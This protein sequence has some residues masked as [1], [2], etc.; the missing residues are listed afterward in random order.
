M[1]PDILNILVDEYTKKNL[2]TFLIRLPGAAETL[3]REEKTDKQNSNRSKAHL[4][5]ERFTDID[6]GMERQ[7]SCI[8]V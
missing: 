8:S 2:L 4:Y 1:S 6:G 5:A 7:T 3:R